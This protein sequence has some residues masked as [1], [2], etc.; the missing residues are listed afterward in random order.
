MSA[1][2]AAIAAPAAPAAGWAVVAF[3]A[4]AAFV[5]LWALN[6]AWKH[7]FGAFLQ[8]LGSLGIAFRAFG[9]SFGVHPFGF[10]HVIDRNVQNYLSSG[11]AASE[12]AMVYALSQAEA[13]LKLAADTTAMLA[14]DVYDGIRGSSHAAAKAIPKAVGK[15]IVKPLE[16]TVVKLATKAT[17]RIGQLD[18]AV[19]RLQH[20]VS[21]L[22]GEVA[23]PFPRIGRVER[24][25]TSLGKRLKAAERSLSVA[26]I[27]ALTLAALGRLGLGWL[28]C[29]NV[30][31][32]GKAVCGM[33]ASWF[34]DVLGLLTD[35]FIL[36]NICRVIPW[37]E[38]GFELVAA[39]MIEELGAVGAGLC[40]KDYSP[41]PRH[42]PPTLHLP[43]ASLT[44]HLP[45]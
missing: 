4:C 34:K 19:A 31:N 45:E 41:A 36:T 30:K 18:S 9:K 15:T 37:I 25:V 1:T 10:A 27:T 43:A 13:W 22:A 38:Q 14:Q 16:R 32:A 11:M 24:D 7:T 33:H 40:N 12:R 26:G 42:A 44:L 23:L 17:T 29:S 5:T 35:F 28:R 3:G 2:V 8:W 20:R 21:V 6:G 39:P